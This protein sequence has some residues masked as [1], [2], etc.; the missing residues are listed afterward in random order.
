MSSCKSQSHKR[1]R[2]ALLSGC[3]RV[4]CYDKG[5]PVSGDQGL[6]RLPAPL[7]R[8]FAKRQQQLTAMKVI[9]RNCAAYLK[10]RNWQWWRLF[11]KVSAPAP[12]SS[13]DPQPWFFAP[14]APDV[15]LE[16]VV[17]GCAAESWR[18]NLACWRCSRPVSGASDKGP[19]SLAPGL[20]P[21]PE[22]RS[23]E[24]HHHKDPSQCPFLF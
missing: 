14:D 2:R 3:C 8:A 10:L 22:H 18:S 24:F 4:G 12:P 5:R 7:P 19:P 9:Q 11:T 23:R 17:S 16:V 13:Q 1:T 6:S 21:G 20:Q 15:G